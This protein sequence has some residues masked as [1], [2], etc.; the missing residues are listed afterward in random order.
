MENTM[1]E[2]MTSEKNPVETLCERCA[3]LT[4]GKCIAEQIGNSLGTFVKSDPNNFEGNWYSYLRIRLS[5]DV[6]FPLRNKMKIK[7][8][9]T[10]RAWILF[11]YERLA[12]F[13]YFC[14]MLGHSAKFFRGALE[15]DLHM[16]S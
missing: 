4:L 5:I 12:T 15:S 3:N 13:C 11:K 10:D 7:K 2:E 9:G 6:N 14:S 8:K 16:H 1:L